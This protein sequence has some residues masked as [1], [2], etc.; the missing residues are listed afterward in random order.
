IYMEISVIV[1]AFNEEENVVP[2]YKELK[3]VL[4]RMNKKYEIIYVNDGSTDRT[5]EV[6][7][8]I[9]KKDSKF[10]LISLS[11]N[12]RKGPALEAGFHYAKGKWIITIDADLQED[13]NDIPRLYRRAQEGFDVVVGWKRKRKDS[14]FTVLK[15][16]IFNTLVRLT[17][18]SKVHD[19]DCNFRCMKKEVA[20]DVPVYAG[21]FRYIPLSA[22][23]KGYKITEVEI[24]HRP[25]LHGKSKWGASRIFFAPLDLMSIK[26]LSSY[27]NRPLHFF[28]MIS[29]FFILI[30]LGITIY[31]SY[32]RLFLRETIGSRPLLLFGV[33]L[34]LVGIQ[35]FTLGLL[36]DFILVHLEKSE[37]HYSIKFTK[38]I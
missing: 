22:Q 10:K 36:G 33:L 20:M 11:K 17:T 15:S 34:L 35:F 25:R 7:S 16:R 1:P 12:S 21:M 29:A 8:A 23:S 9:A 3:Q 27:K 24:N 14:F 13:P 38:N 19:I 6:A 28:G 26:F 37:K 31:L 32:L 30:G 4:E 5:E 18:K 2:L